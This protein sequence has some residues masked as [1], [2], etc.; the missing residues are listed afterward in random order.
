MLPKASRSE[1]LVSYRPVPLPLPAESWGILETAMFR[2]AGILWCGVLA[3]VGGGG[4]G[5]GGRRR[6]GTR[7]RVEEAAWR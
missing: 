5:E 4:G 6:G 2:A 1:I 3:E 7:K